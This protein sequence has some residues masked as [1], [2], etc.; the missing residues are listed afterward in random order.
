MASADLRK[1]L[2]CSVCLNV[3]TDPVMLKCGHNYCRVCIDRVLETQ[4]GAGGYFCPECRETFQ[5]RPALHRNIKLGNVVENFMSIQPDQED[6]GFLCT[7]CVDSPV[8]AVKSCQHCEA[9]LCEKHLKFHNKS[10]EHVLTNPTPFLGNRK[11]RVHKKM[12]EYYCIEDS[13]CVCVSC[14]LAGEHRGH[15]VETF[16]EASEN[17]KQK[18]K[19][20]LPKLTTMREEIETRIQ[21]LGESKKKAEEEMADRN[22]QITAMIS[23][24]RRQLEDLE[25]KLPSK[26][27]YEIDRFTRLSSALEIKKDELSRKM[28]HIEELC[29]TTDPLTVLQESDTGD[30]CDTEEGGNEVKKKPEKQ[31]HDG[32]DLDITGIS[33]SMQTLSVLIRE[34]NLGFYIEEAADISLDADTAF[35]RIQISADGKSASWTNYGFYQITPQRF[36]NYQQVLSSQSF[37]SGR[38][39]WEVDVGGSSAWSV[40]MCFPSISRTEYIGAIGDNDK[41]WCLYFSGAEYQVKHK[42]EVIRLSEPL[43][44]KRVRIY[45]DYEA[46]RLCFYDVCDP[47]RHIHTFTATFTEPLHAALAVLHGCLRIT[48][49]MATASLMKDLECS[50]CLIIYTDPVTLKCG[51]NFFRACIDRVLETKEEAG[52]YSCP[53]YREEI[54]ERPALKR[55]ITLQNLLMNLLST[56]PKLEESGIF[57]TSC[58]DSPVPAVKSCLMCEASLCERHLRV[59][60]KSPEHVLTNPSTAL[61]NRKCPVHKKSLEYYCT[62]ICVSCSLAG[63]HRGNHVETFQEASENKKIK[64]KDMRHIVELCNTTDLL[65]LLQEPD[66]GDLCDTEEGG[67]EDRDT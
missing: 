10:A 43:S 48:G 60:S 67:N 15:R 28:R 25:K 47:I 7:Y 65:T 27:S 22:E 18:L 6:I 64:L 29:N 40:G 20:V 8:A 42:G 53:E 32:G 2:E 4:E 58:I 12:L 61:G 19:N 34:V 59:H 45:L 54:Q 39:Y 44:S 3:Y 30:L 35:V 5:E 16:L 23:D 26:I 57:C 62:P 1:E 52:G 36:Q 50:V 13:T 41:S 11:C 33:V 49:A 51:H 66:T 24:L 63:E 14:S 17:R 56:Q 31:I 46:G 38:H 21:N 37:S 55:N 9:F